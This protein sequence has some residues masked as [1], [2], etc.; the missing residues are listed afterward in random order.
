MKKIVL[1]SEL[2]DG[3]INLLYNE[4]NELLFVDLRDAVMDLKQKDFL[5]RKVPISYTNEKEM[6]ASLGGKDSLSVKEL[7]FTVTFDAWFMLYNVKR[8][9]QRCIKLWDKMSQTDRALAY[10]N[11]RQY[12]RHLQLNSWKTKMEPDTYLRTRAWENEYKD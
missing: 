4:E 12:N 5:V 10:L 6:W 7:P 3:E 2:F 11:H 1:K 8:N 9:K